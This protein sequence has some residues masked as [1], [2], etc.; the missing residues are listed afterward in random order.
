MDTARLS[1]SVLFRGMNEKEITDC[2]EKLGGRNVS[3]RKREY[4][5][6]AGDSTLNMGMVLSGS[7]TIETN[8]LWG[9]RTILSHV[10]ANGYFAETY[11]CIRDAVMPVD[12][13]A[14]EDCEILFLSVALMER[15]PGESWKQKLTQNLLMISMNKNLVL[16][17]RIFNTSPRTIRERVLSYLSSVSLQKRSTEFDIP[18]DR[19][20]LADYLTV[21]R[22]ALSKELGKMKKD[23]LISVRKNHFVLIAKAE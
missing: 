23:G 20:Q 10:G 9:N 21:E 7:V 16:S 5:M 18:F 2:L 8:D 4:I 6:H 12:V 19:Q 22:T 15:Y 13:T 11:A 3:Y 14:S 17:G 1:K